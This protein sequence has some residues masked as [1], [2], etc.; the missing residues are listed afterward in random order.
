M[1]RRIF[2]KN[3]FGITVVLP[4]LPDINLEEP[5]MKKIVHR[6]ETRGLADHGWLKS[7]H[8]FS[9]ANY[10]N[11]ERMRFGL[12]RVLNDDSVAAGEGFGKHPHDNMEII[13]IPLSGSLEH[14]DSMGNKIVIQPNEVQIM[15][16]GTGVKHSEYNH[17]QTEDV[18]FL[19]IWVF[20]KEKNISP[21]YEQKV[22]SEQERKNQLKLVVSPGR[23]DGALWINQDAYF[24][25]GDLDQGTSLNYKIRKEGN[26]VY[27]F[28]L[29]GTIEAAGE[30]LQRRD[31]L[32]VSETNSVDI[33]AGSA[34]KVLLME[35]PM[36]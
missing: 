31:G 1:H 8:T 17:S 26:G 21:R 28:V 29:E 34:A 4:V 36:N 7:Y 13:S 18:K 2:L 25:L 12:L 30:T 15:S 22:F 23:E 35:V 3:L 5:T 16:A 20:P 24:S 10:H 33:K 11:P 14:Q 9:F 6:A 19:Q 27:L 32:G